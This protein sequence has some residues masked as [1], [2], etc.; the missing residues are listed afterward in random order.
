MIFFEYVPH[1][2]ATGGIDW[3]EAEAELT[4]EGDEVSSCRI[5]SAIHKKVTGGSVLC[6]VSISTTWESTRNPKN[7]KSYLAGEWCIMYQW[8]FLSTFCTGLYCEKRFSQYLCV[9]KWYDLFDWFI[10]SHVLGMLS[11]VRVKWSLI[12]LAYNWSS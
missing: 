7:K 5:V 2:A 10:S 3:W 9:Q 8:Y 1:P 12:L 6:T 11:V 4:E